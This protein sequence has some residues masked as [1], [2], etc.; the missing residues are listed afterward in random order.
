WGRIAWRRG[1][2]V[3]LVGIV[4][5]AALAA[6]SVLAYLADPGAIFGWQ[7]VLWLASMGLLLISCARWVRRDS[8]EASLVPAWTRIEVL[9]FAGLVALSLLTRLAFLDRIPWLFHADEGLAY[10]EIMRYYKGP[11]IPL[12]TTTWADTG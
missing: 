4:G 10:I 12:F 5:S 7:G 8:A 6:W 2:A 9:G 3:R 11:M 1:L